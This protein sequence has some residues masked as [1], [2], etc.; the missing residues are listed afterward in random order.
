MVVEAM[1][2]MKNEMPSP[3]EPDLHR[4]H[5]DQAKQIDDYS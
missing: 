1:L 4:K 5:Q 3:I 2:N